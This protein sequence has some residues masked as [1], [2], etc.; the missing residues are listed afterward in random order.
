[1]ASVPRLSNRV[2]SHARSLVPDLQVIWQANTRELTLSSRSLTGA[3]QLDRLCSGWRWICR[4]SASGLQS[5][6]WLTFSLMGHTLLRVRPG[7]AWLPDGQLTGGVRQWLPGVRRPS[8]EQLC[9]VLEFHQPLSQ[10]QRSS[11]AVSDLPP[12][13]HVTQCML[14]DADSAQLWLSRTGNSGSSTLHD[15]AGIP[16]HL[17]SPHTVPP[18][19][20]DRRSPASYLGEM[21]TYLER[22]GVVRDFY[23]EVRLVQSG[24][25]TG[26][27][28]SAKLMRGWGEDPDYPVMINVINP[29]NWQI[30]PPD[31]P[32]AL[33][34]V[35]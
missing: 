30:I 23:V 34:P 1:M 20:G 32:E 18:G 21:L 29:D 9:R 19:Y 13:G 25:L 4:R 6:D 12:Y 7:W 24:L 2:I 28:C 35:L 15:T 10:T 31:Q 3:A 33:L 17:T 8:Y 11:I 26:F 27:L 5:V 22:D 14:G 16:M